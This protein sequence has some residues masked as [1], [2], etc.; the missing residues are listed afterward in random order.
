MLFMLR[1]GFF[2]G[3]ETFLPRHGIDQPIPVVWGY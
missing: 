3:A 2:S 1:T